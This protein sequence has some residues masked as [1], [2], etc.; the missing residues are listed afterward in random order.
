MFLII[1]GSLIL[2]F[3]FSAHLHKY[4]QA[5]PYCFAFVT[6]TMAI[7]C[8]LQQLRAVLNRP[9][10]MIWTFLLAHI[11]SPLVA[12]ALGYMLFGPDSPYVVGLVLF[13][14]IPLGIST[15]LWVGMSAGSV[16]LMLAM[17]VIDSALSPIVVP[18]GIHLL[19][20]TDVETNTA[21]MMGDLLLLIVAPTI[22]GVALH[23]WSKGRIQKAVQPY[24]PPLSKLCFTA[25]VMLNAA[26]IAPSTEALRGDLL[27]VVP[28]ALVMVGLCYA[29][30]YF[31]TMHYRSREVQVTV[32][33]ATGMRNISL[34]VVLAMGY[35]SPLAAVPVVLSILIQ[36]PLATLHHY[37]LQKLN[38]RS[39][40]AG[41]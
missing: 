36:Q 30:G 38:K 4:V 7:G 11:I 27:K 19:F 21:A 39:A 32:S 41:G 9:G 1:P 20:R 34:G 15:V 18:T 6:L 2:G 17:V 22:I 31:G 26:A 28:A 5:V 8:G 29:I 25:V 33:Y 35:F 24:A 13:T 12:Y 23:E 14:I 16:P 3:F 40:G 10:V 37:V